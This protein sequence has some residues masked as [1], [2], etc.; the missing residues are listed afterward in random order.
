MLARLWRPL[1]ALGGILIVIGGPMHPGG[2]MAE[3]LADPA[4]IPSHSWVLA[5]FVALSVA[6]F[7]YWRS[8]AQGPT[9]RRWAALAFVGTLIQTIELV[10]HLVAYVD[11]EHLLAGEPTPVLTTH[12]TLALGAYPVFGLLTAGAIV[13]GVRTGELGRAWFAPLGILGA[14]AHGIAPLL[15]LTFE[16]E[17]ARV[18]FPMVILFALWTVCVALMPRRAGQAVSAPA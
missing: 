18:L 10:F 4:W 9:M 16:I 8:V 15:V 11:L 1:L 13:V 12:L 14:L 17:K 3:M 5:G 2:T 7:G 6:L